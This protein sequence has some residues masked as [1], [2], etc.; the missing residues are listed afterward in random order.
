MIQTDFVVQPRSKRQI[1]DIAEG[2]RRLFRY[3]YEG[4]KVPMDRIYELLPHLRRWL[5]G[6][7]AFLYDIRVEIC[8]R[9]EM[10]DDH[11][12]TIPEH[13][14]IKL[15]EDVYDG[16]CQGK[17]RDCFTGAHELGHL[18][19]HGTVGFSRMAPN[20]NTKLYCKSEWQ[21]NTFASAFLIDEDLLRQCRSIEEVREM[22]GVSQSAAETRFKACS[23]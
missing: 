2:F 3:L 18:L 7:Y 13:K 1:Y 4:S 14:L 5:P 20:A 21:A 8:D 11:G 23:R 12:Q 19:L 6:E 10:G 9:H 15:R 16:M 17:G 22:F